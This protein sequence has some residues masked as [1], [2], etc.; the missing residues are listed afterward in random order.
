MNIAKYIDHT[1]LKADATLKEIEKLCNEAREKGFY[2]VCVNPAYVSHALGFLSG[3]DVKICS[4][5]GFPLGSSTVQTKVYEAVN[6]VDDGADEIDMV[7]NIGYF[8]S[9]LFHLVKNE[10]ERVRSV[11]R[12]SVLKVIIESSLLTDEEIEK[13]VKICIEAGADYAK[14][15]TGF[16][17]GGATEKAVEIMKKAAQGSEIKIKASGGIKDRKTAERYIELGAERIGTS[18]GI[19]ILESREAENGSY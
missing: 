12:D 8:K 13:A 11:I 7:M 10:I 9:G 4:V 16:S 1:C 15:S 19:A 5:V 17:N 14:T 2:S 18:S 6:A 3:T